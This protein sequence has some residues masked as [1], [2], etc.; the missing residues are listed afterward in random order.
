MDLT[1]LHYDKRLYSLIV[2]G[3]KALAE[4]MTTHNVELIKYFVLVNVPSFI[5]AIWTFTKPL[6]PH[7]TRQKV[8]ILSSH[9]WRQEILEYACVESLPDKWNTEN[10]SIFTNHVDLPIP[11]AVENYYRNQEVKVEEL[12]NLQVA[13]GKTVQIYKELKKGERLHW[14]ITTD[15]DFGFG[16]FFSRDRDEKDIEK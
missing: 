16:V 3:M 5:Y 8:R 14:W 4:F 11:Y 13:A 7:R 6:L 15:S 10:M 2:G 12:E 1:G 9:N